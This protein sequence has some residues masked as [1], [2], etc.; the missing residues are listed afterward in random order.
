MSCEDRQELL[1]DLASGEIS[2]QAK[3]EIEA[4]VEVCA[5]CR[6]DLSAYR[7]LFQALPNL[8]E[9]AI[10]VD[11]SEQVM[12]AVRSQR[13]LRRRPEREPAAQRL[14]RRTVLVA[15]ASAF[16]VTLSAALWGWS[17][18]ILAIADRSL[19][20]GLVGFWETAKELW[21]LLQLGRELATTLQPIALNTWS[22]LR[23]VG[24][25]LAGY[26]PVILAAYLGVLLI[27]SLLFWRALSLRDHRRLGHAS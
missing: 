8:P 11:L 21:A 20:R 14:I 17:G 5:A 10:P 22:V 1:Q 2:A 3:S 7:M 24:D 6:R 13:S 16:V 25:P 15:F 18:R 19:S 9:P 26:G 12:A 23:R 4:H 27:G